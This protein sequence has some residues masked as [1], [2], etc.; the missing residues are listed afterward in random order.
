MRMIIGM[1]TSGV[2][3][4]SYV[5]AMVRIF[6]TL[7]ISQLFMIFNI[8]EFI[9]GIRGSKVSGRRWYTL[10]VLLHF[11]TFC[12]GVFGIFFEPRLETFTTCHNSSFR[13]V[14]GLLV[15][16][17]GISKVVD[18]KRYKNN[19]ALRRSVTPKVFLTFQENTKMPSSKLRSYLTR[20]KWCCQTASWR[21]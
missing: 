20:T 6:L 14:F 15:D 4:V 13:G 21:P 5:L 9:L 3:L 11:R 10:P 2:F 16:C 8:Y 7:F 1:T 18:S 17:S 19:L 12:H